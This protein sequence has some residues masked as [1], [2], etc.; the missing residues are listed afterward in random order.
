MVYAVLEEIARQ[1]SGGLQRWRQLFYVLTIDI[2]GPERLLSL[3][4]EQLCAASYATACVI[5]YRPGHVDAVHVT[6]GSIPPTVQHLIAEN[7]ASMPMRQHGASLDELVGTSLLTLPVTAYAETVGLLQLVGAEATLPLEELQLIGLMISNALLRQA[8][9]EQTQRFHQYTLERYHAVQQAVT[10][11]LGESPSL[12]AATPIILQS[13]CESLGWDVGVHWN[14]DAANNVLHCDTIWHAPATNVAEFGAF[15]LQTTYAPGVGL[16]GQVWASG[17]SSWI[18][19]LLQDLTFPG[20]LLAAR[21]HLRTAFCFPILNGREICGVIA[22]FRREMQR[23]DPAQVHMMA[24]FGSQIGQFVEGKLVEH[25]LRESERK[26]RSV[27]EQ[28]REVIFQTD[29]VGHWSFL[30]GAW[31]ELTGF[32]V[33]DSLGT[34][35]WAHVHPDDRQGVADMLQLFIAGHGTRYHYEP[36]YLAKD[37]AVRWVQVHVWPLLGDDGS[38]VGTFE[39]LIDVTGR[40]QAEVVNAELTEALRVE[41]DRLLRREVE[42]RTQIGRDLH[43]GPVQQV[44][45]AELTVQYVRRVAERAPERLAEALNDLQD[46]LKRTTRDL[47][48]VLYELRPLGIAEEGLVVVLQQYIK[49]VNDPNGL[50]IDLDAP[51]NLPRLTPDFEGAVFIIIQEALNNVRKHARAT[52]VWITLRADEAALTAEVRDNGRGFAVDQVQA[53]YVQRGSFGLLNMTERAQLLGGTCT[54]RSKVDHGTTIEVRVP[55]TQ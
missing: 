14:V 34:P 54:I 51:E 42:V 46:Q 55:V 48:T 44:A 22:L 16:P 39:T 1:T 3:V 37:G 2:S 41:R 21:E 27:V 19:D 31:T 29:A 11:V 49:R 25:A 28:V 17:T 26:Y 20:A 6:Y 40:K 30:N 52:G 4:A 38:I 24:M 8:S 13:F 35:V 53:S 45:V 7:I 9:A 23:P 10:R 18:V 32:T 50:Q 47:R 33:E 36:R 12:G 15:C 43:D 5:T